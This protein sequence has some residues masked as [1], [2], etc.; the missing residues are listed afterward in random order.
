MDA[1][2]EEILKRLHVDDVV[3][4][5][6]VCKSWYNLI[7]SNDFVKAHL[8]RNYSSNR[9]HGYLRIRLHPMIN[10]YIELRN[11]MMV[12]SCNGLVCISTNTNNVPEL[13]V[14]NPSTREVR[15]LPMAPYKYRGR[16]CWG[17]GYD[18]STDDYKVVVGFEE[19]MHHMRFQVLSLKSNQWKSLKPNKW[20]FVEDCEY[21]TYNTTRNTYDRGFLYNG[22]LHW[23]MDDTKKKKKVILSF[24]LTLKKFKEI[25][26]PNDMVDM[27]GH[28]NRLG[29][30]EEHLCIC[31]FNCYDYYAKHRQTWVMKSYN[32][33]QLLPRDYEGNKYGSV[34]RAYVLDF[35]P[36]NTW[37]LVFD[38]KRNKHMSSKS[39]LNV[40][41]P[42]F[43]K[44][45]VSPLMKKK[46]NKSE[47]SSKSEF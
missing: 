1:V 5:K 32:G 37:H 19:S 40:G 4:C 2:V 42:I 28:R 46:N 15:Q 44:S 26:L 13:L 14:T 35:I 3:R 30:F 7:S 17:F 34:T 18:S 21:L 20:K 38:H 25:P 23:F 6:S 9:E 36:D 31:E 39:W 22:A 8:K 12:G 10:K 43:V 41:A 47:E 11:C 29:L 16:L 33:W 45:L 27:Y 24:D